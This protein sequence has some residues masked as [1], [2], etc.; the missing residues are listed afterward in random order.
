MVSG[1][2]GGA[3]RAGIRLM[4]GRPSGR[5]FFGPGQLRN[6]KQLSPCRI[7]LARYRAQASPL[8]HAK[9]HA[10]AAHARK[11]VGTG[12]TARAA[13]GRSS[14]PPQLH[15]APPRTLLQVHLC[16]QYSCTISNADR[17]HASQRRLVVP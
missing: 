10:A 16:S 4:H 2:D 13:A 15:G 5:F 9:H 14:S 8:N 6:E 3:V 12:H 7:R 17:H 11:P 1:L